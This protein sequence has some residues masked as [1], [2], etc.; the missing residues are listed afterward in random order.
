MAAFVTVFS[1]STAS[2]SKVISYSSEFKVH[3]AVVQAA[4]ICIIEAVLPVD[5]F[6]VLAENWLVSKHHVTVVTAMRLIS[7][8]QI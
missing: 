2:K 7:A 1:N 8:V 5:L 4:F 3:P 6:E